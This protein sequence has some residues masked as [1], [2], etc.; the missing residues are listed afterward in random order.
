MFYLYFIA[1]VLDY[2]KAQQLIQSIIQEFD[3]ARD[4]K[5]FEQLFQTITTFCQQNNINLNDKPTQHRKRAVSTRFKDSIITTTIGQRD[6]NESEQYYRTCIYYQ[7]IDNI[8]VELNDRFSSNNLQILSSVSSLC[9]DSDMFLH[10]ES[11]K[12]FADHLNFDPGVL[13]NELNVAK[14]MLKA[15]PLSTII[16][17]YLELHPF[18]EAFPILVALIENAITIPVSST[19]CERT[20][21]NMKLIKT[22]MRNT[23]TDNRLSDLC[24]LAVERDIDVNFEQLID[25]LSDIHKNSR[26]MLK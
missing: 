21:S 4:E 13:L 23:M 5:C 14:P 24:V 3:L 12:P 18:K 10:F 20:F 17:L 9:P 6:N 15:K 11:L 26:I 1:K 7:L 16:D 22:A 8:L 25:E 19:T 2:G